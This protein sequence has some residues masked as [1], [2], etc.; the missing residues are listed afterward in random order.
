VPLILG[1]DLNF[2]SES[3]PYDELVG[4][5]GYRDLHADFRALRPDLDS[6]QWFGFTY[7]PIRNSNLWLD[8]P[9]NRPDRY[10]YLLSKSGECA[11]LEVLQTRLLL[12]EKVEGLHLSDHFGVRADVRISNTLEVSGCRPN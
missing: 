2:H 6:V 10:D 1:G 8:R 5:R 7:D 11:Q 9:F 12:D 3:A 4:R